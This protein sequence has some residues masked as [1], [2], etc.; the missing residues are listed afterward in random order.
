MYL[1][2]IQEHRLSKQ[3]SR[4]P[5]DRVRTC[6]HQ[7]YSI[8]LLQKYIFLLHPSKEPLTFQFSRNHKTNYGQG[9]GGFPYIKHPI[10]YFYNR[11]SPTIT[12]SSTKAYLYTMQRTGLRSKRFMAKG[13]MEI[14]TANTLTQEKLHKRSSFLYGNNLYGQKGTKRNENDKIPVDH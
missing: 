10:K 11:Y 8:C 1:F 9:K 3:S 5:T 6:F 2:R 12:Y 14:P 4:Q 7:Q 13:L